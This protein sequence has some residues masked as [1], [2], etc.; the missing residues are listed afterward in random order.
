M[1]TDIQKARGLGYASLAIGATEIAAPRQLERMMGIGNGQNTGILRVLGV[2]EILH[3]ID[4]LTHDD[5]LPGVA[6][7]CAGDVLDSAVLAAAAK[8]TRKPA[9][10]RDRPP[11][12]R[13]T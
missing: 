3:G 10:A 11:A 4:I 5:P 6:G 8:E 9:A 2:R 13:P 12:T 7:R 1:M